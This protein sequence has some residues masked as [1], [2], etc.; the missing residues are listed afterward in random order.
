ME[1]L[2]NDCHHH[3]YIDLIGQMGLV[4]NHLS[5]FHFRVW[6][7]SGIALNLCLLTQQK[8]DEI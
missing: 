2:E 6:W 4:K 3:T 1:D 7:V 5:D 8:V